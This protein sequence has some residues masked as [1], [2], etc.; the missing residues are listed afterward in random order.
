MS[1]L[2]WL[3]AIVLLLYVWYDKRYAHTIAVRRAVDA[4]ERRAVLVDLYNL[5]VDAAAKSATQPFLVY[6]TLLGQVRSNDLI[7]YDYDLDF[8]VRQSEYKALVKEIKRL[9]K[10]TPGMEA[11]VKELFG[12]K[13]IEIVHVPT[14]VSADVFPFIEHSDRVTRNVPKLYSKHYLGECRATYP[15]Q[16]VFPLKPVTFLGKSVHVPNDAAK[17]LEC[18]YGH[19]FMTPDH[20]CSADCNECHR[21]NAA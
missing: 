1:A 21:K 7:C 14:R 20:E 17:L 2:V 10:V 5:V 16:W 4:K 19:T 8:G 13:S 18:Y 11:H 9:V 3:V 6:G 12:Y 15:R